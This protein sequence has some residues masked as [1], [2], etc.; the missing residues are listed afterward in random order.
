MKRKGMRGGYHY[1]S[2]ILRKHNS[3]MNI[4]CQEFS[5]EASGQEPE[6]ERQFEITDLKSQKRQGQ[7]QGEKNGKSKFPIPDSKGQEQSAEPP[8]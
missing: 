5:L 4:A 1:S 3:L 6:P 2:Q 8:K 7:M